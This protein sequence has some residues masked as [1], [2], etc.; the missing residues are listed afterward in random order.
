MK[1]LGK[2][3]ALKK[4]IFT[5]LALTGILSVE[6]NLSAIAAPA[7][8][9]T[10]SS[11]SSVKQLPGSRLPNSVMTAVRTAIARS[12]WT[13][14]ELWKVVSF[15][16]KSWPNN[17]LGLGQS[18]E[19]CGEIFI[20]NGWRVVMANGQEKL[21]AR[22][23]ASG[24]LVRLENQNNPINYLS[25]SLIDGVKKAASQ[26]MGV[27]PELLRVIKVRQIYTNG[28]LNLPR[29]GEGCTKI[30]MPAWEITLDAKPQH[31]VYRTDLQGNQIRFD[32]EATKI[33]NTKA[34]QAVAQAV[35]Q[36]A[37]QDWKLP[38]SAIQITKAQRVTWASGCERP[39]FP[40]P[41]DPFIESGWQV[42]VKAGAKAASYRSNELGSLIKLD[43]TT[44]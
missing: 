6:T 3:I 37:A 18:D 41:C 34:P 19:A 44:R 2:K 24:R 21:V 28:C 16:Q 20:K 38:T 26:R 35:L 11:T 17:C 14:P 5:A 23:D 22:S 8:V 25:P 10:A 33:A 30:N 1:L 40:Y 15:E 32:Q 36:K 42:F 4:Q 12:T 9:S 43:Q 29:P 27:R 31:V 7:I 13:A 39:T